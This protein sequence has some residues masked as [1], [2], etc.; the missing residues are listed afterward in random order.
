MKKR[1]L[2][3]VAV[4]L[5]V[6][7]FSSKAAVSNSQSILL[8]P[9]W[10]IVSTPKIVESHSFSLPETSDNFDIYVLNASD[11]VGWSTLADI[12]QTEFAPLYG[13][14]INNKSISAQTLVLNYLASTTPNQR[15]FERN[16]PT[17]GWYSLGIANPTYANKVT[18]GTSDTN[19]PNK[20][21]NS[22]SG[23]YDSVV[24]LTDGSFTQNPNN[25]SVDNAWKQAVASD[26]NSLNDLRETKGYAIYITRPG[27]LYSGFQ[28]ESSS[29]TD[30]GTSVLTIVADANQVKS[31]TVKVNATDGA[32]GIPMTSFGVNSTIGNS[33]VTDV[34]LNVT[35]SNPRAMPST[36]YIYDGST[37]LGSI[38]ATASTT[39]SDLSVAV[40]KDT[41][42]TFTVRA[43]FPTTALAADTA[44]VSLSASGITYNKPDGSSG[45]TTNDIIVGNVMHLYPESVGVLTLISATSQYTPATDWASSTLKGTIVMNLSADGAQVT[46]PTASNFT[47]YFA[48]STDK[49]AAAANGTAAV[50]K[51]LTVSP[52]Q[53]ITDGS[54]ATLTLDATATK[55]ATLSGYLN[56]VLTSAA[57]TTADHTI[58]QTWGLDDFHTPAMNLY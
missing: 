36:I 53:T 10:N 25:V 4:A 48:S 35:A 56:L 17:T 47:L 11:T 20:I 5:F 30:T 38:T 7:P 46:L 42:K 33:V 16:F 26:I 58:T 18:D 39:L 43:D 28:N 32:R 27:S 24:D 12:G 2:F 15:F 57:I 31:T 6:L 9:G 34:V 40:L 13:Y 37:L 54:S 14:F 19:N 55:A 23:G 50:T 41:T 1:L 29:T 3:V 49:T 22:V 45:I 21:L 44:A 51:N 8:S 52:S